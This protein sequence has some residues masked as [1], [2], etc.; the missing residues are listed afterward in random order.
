V[1]YSKDYPNREPNNLGFV[2]YAELK[3]GHI[4]INDRI[5]PTGSLS[6]IRKAKDIAG[7]LKNWIKE[8]KFFLTESLE[9]V[10]SLDSKYQFKVLKERKVEDDSF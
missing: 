2:S 7:I 8:G 1:D 10:P 4:K 6:S 3:S 9:R 5:V